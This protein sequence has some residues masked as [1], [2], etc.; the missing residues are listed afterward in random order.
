MSSRLAIY[1]MLVLVIV[2]TFNVGLIILHYNGQLG[3][4]AEAQ[5]TPVKAFN[6]NNIP[7]SPAL[8]PPTPSR[9][10]VQ[11]A[12]YA[13]WSEAETLAR[14]LSLRYRVSILVVPAKVNSRTYYRVRIPLETQ[15]EAQAL[16]S[17]LARESGLETWVVSLK[18]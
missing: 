6:K 5:S 12:A 10:A 13:T 18:H 16:A 15:A 17:R 14:R 3:S 2:W 7:E 8:E 9:F 1:T 11:V 4:V